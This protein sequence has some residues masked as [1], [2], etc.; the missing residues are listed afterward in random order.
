MK[1]IVHSNPLG[2][3]QILLEENNGTCI[4]VN[5]FLYIFTAFVDQLLANYDI[6]DDGRLSFVEFFD[7]YEEAKDKL[8]IS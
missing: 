8:K 7:S 2:H 5:I 4:H 6:D 1:F 3:L